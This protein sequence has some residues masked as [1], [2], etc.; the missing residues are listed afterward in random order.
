MKHTTGIRGQLDA[1]GHKVARRAFLAA[2]AATGAG[3]LVSFPEP[4]DA[5]SDFPAKPVKLVIPYPAGG[6]TDIVGRVLAQRLSEVWKQPVL[7]DNRGGASGMIG[8]DIVAKSPADG[9]TLMVNVSG[10]LVNPALYTR[11][12]HDPL[13]DFTPITNVAS[14]PIQLVI[15]AASPV[16]TVRDLVEMVRAQPGKF[17]FA[18]S[19]SGTP[20][21]LA[22]EVFKNLARLEVTHVPYKGSAPALTDIIG[23]QVTY[24]FDS[25]PSS[26]QLV[27]GGKLRSLALTSAQRSA[28]LPD[29]PTFA[30]AGY[31]DI[32]LS[33]WYGMWAPA[34]LPSELLQ[35]INAD[36]VAVLAQADVRQRFADVLAE[37]VGD[38]ASHFAAYCQ[39]ESA[40][41][42]EIVR[43]AGI[44]LD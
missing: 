4:A 24:M 23:G 7:V 29:V 40:R 39:S 16:R 22:G 13:K 30:E 42:A 17:T 35:R 25:M 9:Y 36:V 26:I 41:Y 32:N 8:A 33:T 44:R 37:A 21:H 1:A 19:S 10:Q 15:S 28:V 2:L 3:A 11:M 12:P 14:T 34:G 5:A 31:P 6:P 20:G 38:S 43:M 18:S 27:K